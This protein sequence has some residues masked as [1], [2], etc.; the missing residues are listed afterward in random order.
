MLAAVPLAYVLPALCYLQL[1]EGHIFSQR[2]IPA[3]FVVLFGLIVAL[4]GVIFLIVD[5]DTVDTCSHGRV[6]EY[7][8]NFSNT[9]LNN[10][11]LVSNAVRAVVKMREV[12]STTGK[13]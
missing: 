5:F 1:E 12:N 2:K 7:C 13:V 10:K 11:T 8:N 3:L 4:F 6:M 9:T